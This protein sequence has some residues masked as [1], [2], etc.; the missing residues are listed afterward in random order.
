VFQL[1][2]LVLIC[3]NNTDKTHRA[4]LRE[5]K[6]FLRALHICKIKFL[7]QLFTVYKAQWRVNKRLLHC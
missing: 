2:G 3:K 1:Y 4:S 6:K 7:S 5:A